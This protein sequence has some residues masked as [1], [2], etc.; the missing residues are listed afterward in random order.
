MANKKTMKRQTKDKLVFELNKKQAPFVIGGFIIV[1]ILIFLIGMIIGSNSAKKEFLI[2][3]AEAKKIKVS[4]PSLLEE[5]LGMAPT[6]TPD[7]SHM[8]ENRKTEKKVVAKDKKS[9]KKI[10]SKS[11]NGKH[12]G[13]TDSKSAAGSKAATGKS[14]LAKPNYY[15]QVGAFKNGVDAGRRADQLKKKGYRVVVIKASIPDKGVWH[16][17]RIGPFKKLEE[18]KSFSLKFEKKEKISTFITRG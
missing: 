11:G 14:H 8:P 7:T 13:V 3:A 15:I 10:L 16:R 2:T 1:G 12:T 6:K 4:A 9:V 17:V 5:K 18:A